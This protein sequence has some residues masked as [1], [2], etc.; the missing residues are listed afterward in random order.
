VTD[1]R[2]T[3]TS[4]V[5]PVARLIERKYREAR[6]AGA[7]HDQAI[8]AVRALRKLS[9]PAAELIVARLAEEIDQAVRVADCDYCE[10]EGHTFRTCPARDDEAEDDRG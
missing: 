6:S 3:A 2:N 9:R 7:T 1:T 10:V 8:E 4:P 5:A